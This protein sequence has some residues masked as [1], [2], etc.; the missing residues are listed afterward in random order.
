MLKKSST[1]L[2]AGLAAMSW[3]SLANSIDAQISQMQQ[4]S[5]ALSQGKALYSST[6]AS[7]H[8]KD[9]SGGTGF[10]LK[11]GEWIHG[12]KPSE[13]LSNIKQGFA[14][15]GMPAFN[16]VYNDKQLKSIVA[17]ILS[18]RRGFDNLSYQIY[19][20]PDNSKKSFAALKTLKVAKQGQFNNNL[21]N[22]DLPEVSDFIMQIEGDFYADKNQVTLLK[23]QFLPPHMLVDV[24]IDGEKVDYSEPAWGERAWPLK[25]GK[26]NI[27][28][29]YNSLEKPEWQGNGLH[30]FVTNKAQTIKLYPSSIQAKAFL[31]QA[32]HDVLADKTAIVQRK[33]VVNLPTFS[34]SVGL[35]EKLN[36]AF[37]TKSCAIVGFWQGDMLNIGPNI[38][39]R[40]KDGSLILGEWQFHYPQQIKPELAQTT[41][42]SQCQFK[43]YS[44]KGY[45]TIYYRLNGAEY[46]VQGIAKQDN[47]LSFKYR[48]LKPSSQV[49]NHQLKFNLP[50][51]DKVSFA[52]SNGQIKNGQFTVDFN[53]HATAKLNLTIKDTK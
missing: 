19:H 14:T 24:F 9:L 39:A 25:P 51:T 5:Q 33:K 22:F 3:P 45:P 35:T 46:S 21:A 40:G 23:T 6:C 16:A 17:Y 42:Q 29:R 44:D 27:K 26:Q 41:E 15:G 34:L 18:E 7:C 20:L 47:Q 8:A 13:I 37:N 49:L 10:N 43:K 4:Q 11:D 31:E 53:Q 48:L 36:Y 12:S 50:A 30:F 32:K 28:I 1:L 38:L 52:S 2:T